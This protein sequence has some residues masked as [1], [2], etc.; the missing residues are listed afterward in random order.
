MFYVIKIWN[1][2][3]GTLAYSMYGH[4]GDIKTASFSAKGDF[5]G[6]GGADGTLL[7]WK[8]GFGEEKG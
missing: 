4:T 1:L 2:K 5:F 8:S 3:K 6:T 7:I